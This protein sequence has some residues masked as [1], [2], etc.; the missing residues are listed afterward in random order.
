MSLIPIISFIVDSEGPVIFI[1]ETYQ[2]LQS[3]SLV[4]VSHWCPKMS[5]LTYSSELWA[6]VKVYNLYAL[7]DVIIILSQKSILKVKVL[8]LDCIL[9]SIRAISMK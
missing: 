1:I 5:L 6:S 2:L 8:S 7:H 4:A 9:N 3:S